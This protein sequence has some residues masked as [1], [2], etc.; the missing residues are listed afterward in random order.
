MSIPTTASNGKVRH[1]RSAAAGLRGTAVTDPQAIASQALTQRPVLDTCGP[2]STEPGLGK[3]WDDACFDAIR[4]IPTAGW[5]CRLAAG[6][7]SRAVATG[8]GRM[9]RVSLE[10]LLAAEAALRW[11][12]P[13]EPAARAGPQLQA[14]SGSQPRAGSVP[15]PGPL[16]Q[17]PGSLTARSGAQTKSPS[18]TLLTPALTVWRCLLGASAAFC[19]K[20]LTGCQ[21]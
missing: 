3:P 10:L 12:V 17:A 4:R 11:P 1:K 15:A 13:A 9:A 18:P 7:Q 20:K 5:A 2:A 19:T 6:R 21:R 16:L 8:E 14:R